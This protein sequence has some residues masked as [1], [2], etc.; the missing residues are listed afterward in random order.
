ME[1]EHKKV[2]KKDLK[3]IK[4][5]TKEEI[6]LMSIYCLQTY[7][8][9][10][11]AFG[12]DNIVTQN[13][14]NVW[15]EFKSIIDIE[16]TLI[17]YINNNLAK[18]SFSEVDTLLDD[19]DDLNSETIIYYYQV[20]DDIADACDMKESYR[21][22]RRKK[23]FETL[24]EESDLPDQII[25]LAM[26][27]KDIK[28]FLGCNDKLWD[29]LQNKI[30]RVDITTKEAM[31]FFGVYPKEENGKVADFKVIVPY[32]FN[33]ETLLINVHEFQHA[34]DVYNTL[35]KCLAN[36]NEEYELSARAKEKEFRKNYLKRFIDK[37]GSNKIK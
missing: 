29:F 31:D 14:F 5:A 21:A 25:A 28:K 2:I 8:K 23:N 6:L 11:L 30:I 17:D 16:K 37:K 3:D 36:D 19:M 15:N 24:I 7:V 34:I 33:L 1:S 9:S 18:I 32:I 13:V 27:E 12:K 10:I 20:L 35:G 4:N 26:D 22:I